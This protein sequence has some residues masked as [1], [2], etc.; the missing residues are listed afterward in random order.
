MQGT[1]LLKDKTYQLTYQSK[2]KSPVVVMT[3][4]KTD[5][6][7]IR[8]YELNYSLNQNLSGASAENQPVEIRSKTLNYFPLEVG[9]NSLIMIQFG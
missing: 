5:F 2:E 8:I 6:Y 9:R 7:I 1:S 3:K 4:F